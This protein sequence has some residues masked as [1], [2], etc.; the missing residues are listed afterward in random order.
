[1]KEKSQILHP[2]PAFLTL[3]EKREHCSILEIALEQ[4][5]KAWRMLQ[6]E[7]SV[8]EFCSDTAENEL[9]DIEMS[10]VL[11]ILVNSWWL[12]LLPT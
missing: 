5:S 7:R 2:T 6:N 8:V 9:S 11:A 3:R 12:Q 4:L 1:M 10:M